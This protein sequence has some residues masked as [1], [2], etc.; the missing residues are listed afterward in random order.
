MVYVLFINISYFCTLDKLWFCNPQEPELV[1]C[2]CRV[3]LFRLIK[4]N[5]HGYQAHSFLKQKDR[6]IS[7]NNYMKMHD[8]DLEI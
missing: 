2:W 7:K 8:Y 4:I 3:F 6:Q 5:G 1:A